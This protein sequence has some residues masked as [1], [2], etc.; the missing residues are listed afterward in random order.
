MSTLTNSMALEN[1]LALGLNING[2]NALGTKAKNIALFLAAPFIGLA[3]L[4]AFPVVGLG[5]IAWIAC[6]ALMNNEKA[7]PVALLIAAPLI[8]LV[9]VAAGPVVAL[10]ALV[11]IG[12]EAL[13]KV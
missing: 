12:C 9:F 13:L 3:Y 2:E 6:K 8:A 11:R 7:R 10:G 4:L 1:G 5:M